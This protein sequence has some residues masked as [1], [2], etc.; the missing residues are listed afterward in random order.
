[1]RNGFSR[2]LR[3]T[4]LLAWQSARRPR[5]LSTMFLRTLVLHGMPHFENMGARI[6]RWSRRRAG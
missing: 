2:R 4:L 1:V 5:W 6:P 3:P